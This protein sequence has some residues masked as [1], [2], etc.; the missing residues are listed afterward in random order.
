VLA[1]AG[2]PIVLLGSAAWLV[3]IQR[4][5]ITFEGELP[6]EALESMRARWLRGHVIRTGVAL[7]S[8]TLAVVAAVS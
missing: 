7:V 4:R 5:L 8:L 2:F 1:A 6:S 3:P